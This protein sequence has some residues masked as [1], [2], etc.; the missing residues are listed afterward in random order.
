MSYFCSSDFSWQLPTESRSPEELMARWEAVV[1]AMPYPSS[2]EDW[3]HYYRLKEAS[4]P[5]YYQRESAVVGAMF[6]AAGRRNEAPRPPMQ[7]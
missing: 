3:M 7:P 6:Q 2:F 4:F 5:Q 1:A